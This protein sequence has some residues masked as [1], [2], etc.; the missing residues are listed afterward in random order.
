MTSTPRSS[1]LIASLAGI[2]GAAQVL[3]EPADID[4]VVGLIEQAYR[5]TL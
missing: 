2:V 5:L 1:D 4:Y 3:S